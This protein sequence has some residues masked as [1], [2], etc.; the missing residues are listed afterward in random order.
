VDRDALAERT[1]TAMAECL[2]AT[3]GIPSPGATER[4]ADAGTRTPA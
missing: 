2:A 1:R 3:Y 4:L